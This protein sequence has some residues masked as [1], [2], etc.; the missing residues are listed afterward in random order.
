MCNSMMISF[1][2]AGCCLFLLLLLEAATLDKIT[3]IGV[4]M[5]ILVFIF[6][7]LFTSF[8]DY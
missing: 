2:S 6:R 5:F 4:D 7:D 1:S 3:G 8:P